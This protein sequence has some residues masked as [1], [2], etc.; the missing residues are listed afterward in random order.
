LI[1]DEAQ[2]EKAKDSIRAKC[3]QYLDRAEKLKQF[4]NKKSKKPVADGGG[5]NNKGFVNVQ[6]ECVK[7]CPFPRILPSIDC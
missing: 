4:L 3:A 6:F 1:V 7:L 2:S 5:S